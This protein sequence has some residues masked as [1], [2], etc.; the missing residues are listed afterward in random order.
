M[1]GLLWRSIGKER[2]REVRERIVAGY[3][4]CVRCPFHDRELHACAGCGCFMPFKLAAGGGC[5]ARE[6]DPNSRNGFSLARRSSR[7]SP[8]AGA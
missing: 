5:W 3:R 6:T 2:P 8:D 7:E 4:I 1:A